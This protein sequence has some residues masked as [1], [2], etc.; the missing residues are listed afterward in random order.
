MI[1]EQGNFDKEKPEKNVEKGYVTRTPKRGFPT[2]EITTKVK[3]GEIIRS[4]TRPRGK[5]KKMK[6]E[7]EKPEKTSDKDNPEKLNLYKETPT[8]VCFKNGKFQQGKSQ[9]WKS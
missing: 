3:S 8:K 6:P 1:V 9:E 4:D 7:K 5:P 2:K